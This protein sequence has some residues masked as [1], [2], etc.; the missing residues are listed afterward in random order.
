MLAAKMALYKIYHV[1]DKKTIAAY[2]T[3][4]TLFT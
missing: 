4:R 2:P 3:K 1:I